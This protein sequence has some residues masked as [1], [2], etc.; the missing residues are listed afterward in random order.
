MTSS[1]DRIRANFD[2]NHIVSAATLAP[3]RAPAKHHHRH[4]S[5]IV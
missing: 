2:G 1:R 3:G 5:R 4:D